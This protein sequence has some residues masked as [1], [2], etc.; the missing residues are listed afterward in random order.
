M[1][2]WSHFG[3]KRL[4]R[5]WRNKNKGTNIHHREAVVNGGAGWSGNLVRVSKKAHSAYHT[6][7]RTRK[8][9]E[10]IHYL[11]RLWLPLRVT[12]LAVPT[13]RLTEVLEELVQRG[14][15]K[16]TDLAHYGVTTEHLRFHGTEE[17]Q[18]R[19][20]QLHNEENARKRPE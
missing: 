14:V 16:T 1:N 3:E 6:F 19:Y 20:R 9:H 17:E 2:M 5:L 10:I 7:F 11:N 12:V 18:Q 8:P 15:L 13:N 4:R